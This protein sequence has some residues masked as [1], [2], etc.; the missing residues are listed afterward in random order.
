MVETA[1]GL[2]ALSWSLDSPIVFMI[3]NCA[4]TQPSVQIRNMCYMCV[5]L[6]PMIPR[7]TFGEKCR[8]YLHPKLIKGN[9]ASCMD[10]PAP[11]LSGACSM[12]EALRSWAAK[13]YHGHLE[14]QGGRSGSGIQDLSC[15]FRHRQ[16]SVGI[17]LATSPDG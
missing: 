12:G 4:E 14:N 6:E 11:I 1:A 15:G 13:N 5:V 3:H 17:A 8:D 16:P 10:Q 9:Q 2:K 7:A